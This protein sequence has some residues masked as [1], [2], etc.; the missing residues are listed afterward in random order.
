MKLSTVALLIACCALAG[1]GKSASQKRAEFMRQCVAAEFQVPQC[2]F[3]LAMQEAA[4]DD[5]DSN[6]AIAGA[7]LGLAATSGVR[8]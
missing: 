2:A 4:E 5:S 1:C 8:R 6:G 7:A 3:L